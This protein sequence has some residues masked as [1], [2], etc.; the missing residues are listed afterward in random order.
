MKNII[1]FILLS[2]TIPFITGCDG[3]S[4]VEPNAV[5]IDVY[6]NYYSPQVVVHY[7]SSSYY[8]KQTFELG[9]VCASWNQPNVFSTEFRNFV[10]STDEDVMRTGQHQFVI[11]GLKS[12]RDYYVRGYVR[13][14]SGI[15]YSGT[16]KIRN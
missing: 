7:A 1:R 11:S 5:N 3:L 14:E 9:Y 12:G 2:L 8:D 10:T 15:T 16:I 4:K 6:T 13:N